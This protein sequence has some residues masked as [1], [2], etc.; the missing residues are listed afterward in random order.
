MRTGREAPRK[1]RSSRNLNL[2]QQHQRQQQQQQQNRTNRLTAAAPSVEEPLSFR[3][4]VGRPLETSVKVFGSADWR[5]EAVS[6]IRR[7]QC[8]VI[9]SYL[10]DAEDIQKALLAELRRRG[11]DFRCAVI[12]DEGM[13][14][15]GGCRRQKPMLKT[16]K[17]AGAR[18]FLARGQHG[19]GRM[20][21]YPGSFHV[22]CMV[23]DSRIAF[24]GSS[25]F[26]E[27]SMKNWEMVLRVTGSAVTDMGD[28]L[29]EAM[30]SNST[31][32]FN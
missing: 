26:T 25:N 7:A 28:I 18:I 12:V 20:S 3:A 23:L 10:F 29:K 17:E 11:K 31:T 27:A 5:E 32:H 19:G 4:V 24:V 9:G 6:D 21:K 8:V 2:L 30:S 14:N 16:L 22:K 1:S 13:H 15:S